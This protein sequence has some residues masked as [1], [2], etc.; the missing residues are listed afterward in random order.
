[1]VCA[2]E[3]QAWSK[4]FTPGIDTLVV[5]Y[6]VLE[7]A[8]R[9]HTTR[10][11][12][13]LFTSVW[14]GSGWGTELQTIREWVFACQMKRCDPPS[15]PAVWRTYFLDKKTNESKRL[16]SYSNLRLEFLYFR[17][18]SRNCNLQ[19]WRGQTGKDRVVADHLFG[20]VSAL[21]TT[22]SR[23]YFFFST[24]NRVASCQTFSRPTLEA[25]CLASRCVHFCPTGLIFEL[26]LTRPRGN[27]NSWKG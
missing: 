10:R 3:L 8:E 26:Q 4:F 1:M 23:N 25:L 15:K 12:A 7:A 27:N 14:F 11:E 16:Q 21:S 2:T 9:K 19:G 17:H 18:D 22:L 6:V 20:H 5:I 13:S 24:S